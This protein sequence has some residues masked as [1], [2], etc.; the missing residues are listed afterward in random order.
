MQFIN[1]AEDATEALESSSDGVLPDLRSWVSAQDAAVPAVLVMDYASATHQNYSTCDPGY[2][3][4]E[5]HRTSSK[6]GEFSGGV[7]VPGAN[8]SAQ[9]GF[10]STQ[11]VHHKFSRSGH[12]CGSGGEPWGSAAR[13]STRTW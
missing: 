3:G 8:L 9:S 5:Y 11:E 12:I 2:A 1:D 13:V 7:S 4:H 10:T 6:N